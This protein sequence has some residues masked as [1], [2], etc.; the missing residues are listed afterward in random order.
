MNEAIKQEQEKFADN[1]KN[2]SAEKVE[3]KSLAL[4]CWLQGYEAGY[5]SAKNRRDNK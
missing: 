1:F 3:E 4:L 5:Q 2:I